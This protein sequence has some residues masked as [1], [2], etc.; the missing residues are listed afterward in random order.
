VVPERPIEDNADPLVARLPHELES[1]L[2]ASLLQPEVWHYEIMPWPHRI[3][4]GHIS[5]DRSQ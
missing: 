3:F 2:I 5:V 4:Q 1:T